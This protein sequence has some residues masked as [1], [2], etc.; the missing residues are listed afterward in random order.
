MISISGLIKLKNYVQLII[1][2]VDAHI[3]DVIFHEI[4]DF[5]HFNTKLQA[6]DL[7]RFYSGI[8]FMSAV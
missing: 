4:H 3:Q 5:S 1:V 7:Y 2:T 6:L 8:E